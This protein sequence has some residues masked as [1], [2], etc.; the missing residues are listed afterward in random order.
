[1]TTATR[2][3]SGVMQV[4][5]LIIAFL[6]LI[7]AGVGM[8]LSIGAHGTSFA[9]ALGYLWQDDGS[10]AAFSVRE[11]RL[12]RVLCALGV[13][14]ALALS[15]AL[16]Q[17]VTRN[18]LGDPGLTGVSG[19]AAFGVALCLTFLSQSAGAIVVSGIAGGFVAAGLTFAIAGHSNLQ[20]MRLILAG[21]AVSIF[22]IAATSAVM[23]LSKSSMQTLYYWMIGGFI[24]RDWVEW[25]MFWPWAAG[26]A[27][28]AFALSP[29]LRLL[30]FEDALAASMGLRAERWR[31]VAGAVSVLL[32]AS[33][34]AV[35]GPIAFIGF[36]APHLARLCL[37]QNRAVMWLWLLCATLIGAVVVVWADTLARVY[38]SGRAPAGVIITL[39]GGVAFLLLVRSAGRFRE[40]SA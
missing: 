21:V 10:N 33:A 31:L 1:M 11:L 5:I 40:R 7:L 28:A 22:F 12:P 38:F 19:G 35:A 39:I 32:A 27:I 24:N 14:A 4:V 8:S 29:V 15:G 26:S 20:P 3:A 16:I 18:P 30:A 6:A 2:S 34:V 25:V 9:D 17:V 36:V 23:I 13:G 37:G